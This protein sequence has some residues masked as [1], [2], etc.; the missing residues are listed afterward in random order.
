[1]KTKREIVAE[2]IDSRLAWLREDLNEFAS[3]ILDALEKEEKCCCGEVSLKVE[4]VIHRKSKPCYIAEP[5]KKIE[6]LGFSKFKDYETYAE[7]MEDVVAKLNE[8]IRYINGEL[9]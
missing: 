8:V 1:M 3:Q 5:K 7:E 2:V 4:D 9:K 6:E